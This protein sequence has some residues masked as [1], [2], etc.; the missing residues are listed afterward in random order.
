[1][2][3]DPRKTALKVLN[4]LSSGE[5]TLDAVIDR[6]EAATDFADSR[7]R[8]LFNTLVYGTL[9]WQG[10]LDHILAHFANRPLKKLDPRILNVLRIGL[11]QITYLDRIPPSAAVNTAVN[12]V[13][14]LAAPWAVPFV[15]AVLR[16]AT[17]ELDQVPFPPPDDP[18]AAALAVNKSCPQWLVERW[19]SRYGVSD[20]IRLCDAVNEPA[21]VT[22]RVNTLKTNV[23]VLLAEIREALGD[24]HRTDFAPDGI[25]LGRA[26]GA[27]F[28]HSFYR[29]G[30]CAVQDEAAQLIGLLVDPQP[31]DR[32]LDGCAGLGGKSAHMAQLMQNRGRVIAVDRS[33]ARLERLKAEM[34]RLGITIVKPLALP[35]EKAAAGGELRAPFDR[36]LVDA[37]CSGLGVIRR[38][39]DIKWSPLKADLDRYQRIQAHLLEQA[40]PLVRPEGLLVYSVCSSEP[41]ET[42]AVVS[43]FLKN[44]PEFAIS[45]GSKAL[46]GARYAPLFCGTC[47]QTYPKHVEMDG[48]FGVRFSR[49]R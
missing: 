14:T 1:M 28:K 23:D 5:I 19:L 29:D 15:N 43:G 40:A 45:A 21:T 26:A 42:A 16:R 36:I 32:V 27:L 10:R 17:S 7:D 6:M 20:T 11:F 2:C 18:S 38:N 49:V 4:R 22:L 34:S 12:L 25:R 13:R 30:L 39:P 8:A 44:H 35:L 33:D 9:R 47:L 41:E 37:P 46:S 3:S 31:G 48:F 24:A